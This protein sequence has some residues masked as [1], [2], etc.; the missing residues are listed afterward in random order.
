MTI[1]NQLF[2]ETS[3]AIDS[4]HFLADR[5]KA[6]TNLTEEGKA[7][8]WQ[9][10]TT[11]HRDYAA[12][13]NDQITQIRAAAAAEVSN[14]FDD[15]MPAATTDQGRIASELAAQRVIGRGSLTNLATVNQWFTQEPASPARTL[16][17]NELVARNVIEADHV[18]VLAQQA[19]PIYAMSIKNQSAADTILVNLL[20]RKVRQLNEKLADRTKVA[21]NDALDIT[22][23]QSRVDKI[24]QIT[25]APTSIKPFSPSMYE[26]QLRQ[27]G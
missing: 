17:V 13:L 27:H 18:D 8:Q 12:Y 23:V 7:T 10:Q 21:V 1:Y 14:A 24:M 16:V 15:E 9:K 25:G 4:A 26:R 19:S 5:I 11:V 22:A 20:Q 2:N 3:A 6:D